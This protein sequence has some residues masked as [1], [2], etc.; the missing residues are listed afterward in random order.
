MG[1]ARL[2]N[3]QLLDAA[4]TAGFDVLLSSDKTIKYEQNMQGRKIGIA[5]MSDN[6]WPAVEQYGAAIAEAVDAVRQGEVLQVFCGKFVP[7]K[8]RRPAL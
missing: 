2:K 7:A 8:F 6:H 3:G 4:E 1:W 5:S